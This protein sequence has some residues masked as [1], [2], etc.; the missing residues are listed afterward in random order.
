MSL[1]YEYNSYPWQ[2]KNVFKGN[3]F[4]FNT[5]LGNNSSY[6]S[7]KVNLGNQVQTTCKA[8]GCDRPVY[9]E[10]NGRK[11]PCCGIVCARSFDA[12]FSNGR[13]GR[14]ESF[15]TFQRALCKIWECDKP[16]YIEPS[17][18]RHPYCS[19]TCARKDFQRYA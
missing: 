2:D 19:R 12:S 11:H 4:D 10:K 18:I 8:S 7:L 6:S 16:C 17:G 14:D 5:I 15:P 9:V 13:Q 1:S 3:L